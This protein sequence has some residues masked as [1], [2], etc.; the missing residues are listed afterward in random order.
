MSNAHEP[1]SELGPGPSLWTTLRVFF[2]F[3]SPRSF[4]VAL[5]I[6]IEVEMTP[7]VAAAL[8]FI[9]LRYRAVLL[10]G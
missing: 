8:T 3:P 1:K 10:P 7:Y 6:L 4:L 2:G 9:F 5:P